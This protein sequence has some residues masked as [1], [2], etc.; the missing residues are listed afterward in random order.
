MGDVKLEPD[1]STGGN[2][3]RK[4]L[5]MTEKGFILHPY[6]FF[7]APREIQSPT[8]TNCDIHVKV[9][10]INHSLHDEL[11]NPAGLS[12]L[13]HLSALT[14]FFQPAEL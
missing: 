13:L 3:T 6:V 7:Q 8:S 5:I 12:P 1:H 4:V 14:W 11:W 2:D 9:K 10:I